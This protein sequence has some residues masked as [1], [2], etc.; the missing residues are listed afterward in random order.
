MRLILILSFTENQNLHPG[1]LEGGG[2]FG[3]I[4]VRGGGG[5]WGF[6]LF[7]GV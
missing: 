1:G 2:V 7:N 3:G 4:G 6:L 5:G